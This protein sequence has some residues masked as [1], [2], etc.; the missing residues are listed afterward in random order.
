MQRG[1]TKS[2]RVNS[3][4][5]ANVG[6]FVFRVRRQH[7]ELSV[8]DEHC[9]NFRRG[10]AFIYVPPRPR[11]QSSSSAAKKKSRRHAEIVFSTTVNRLLCKKSEYNSNIYG[12]IWVCQSSSTLDYN[13]SR[14]AAI[15]INLS[16]NIG[17]V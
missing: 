1:E 5:G 4:N 16:Q 15:Y 13:V 9:R 8:M 7:H 12:R 6:K 10:R 2:G 17:T 3:P 11:H 14:E